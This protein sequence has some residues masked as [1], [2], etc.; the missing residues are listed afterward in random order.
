MTDDVQNDLR[1][2]TIK[3][4]W[5]TSTNPTNDW[6]MNKKMAD[7]MSGFGATLYESTDFIRLKDVSLAYDIPKAAI[8]RIGL[9]NIRV[10]VSGRNLLTF[11][12]WSGLDPE[13]VDEDAQR[14]I[15]M[16]KELFFGLTF[17][18]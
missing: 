6:V 5:W 16:Q 14:N 1:Y 2:N 7:Q 13:L 11:T 3:K 12:K 15:P 9:S 17:G 18:F 4:N 10:Y 8:S